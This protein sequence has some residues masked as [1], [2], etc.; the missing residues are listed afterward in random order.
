MFSA[1]YKHFQRSM[2]LLNAALDTSD[3]KYAPVGFMKRTERH[4]A[5]LNASR[6]PE[7][8]VCER[9]GSAFNADGAALHVRPLLGCHR[10]DSGFATWG[11][12][13]KTLDELVAG[14]NASLTNVPAE[15][16]AEFKMGV[17]VSDLK[18][19]D[20]AVVKQLDLIG[21]I[22]GLM[23]RRRRSASS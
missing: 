4:T 22:V 8:P 16:T 17:S 13:S 23:I 20:D 15:E 18:G 10:P 6:A 3:G 5:T 1:I 19:S 7:G 21:T 12:L 2:E 9:A 11:A 14:I